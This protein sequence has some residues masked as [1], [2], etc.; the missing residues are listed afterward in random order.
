MACPLLSSLQCV[1]RQGLDDA[2]L[3]TALLL[4]M[5]WEQSA[6]AM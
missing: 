1:V 4:L 2:M 6:D 5:G 3:Q